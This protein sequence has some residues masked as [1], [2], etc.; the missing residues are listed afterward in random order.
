MTAIDVVLERYREADS[1]ARL[2][3]SLGHRDLRTLFEWIEEEERAATVTEVRALP[4]GGTA[5]A[6]LRSLLRWLP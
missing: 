5:V 2:D 6:P 3:M 1:Q 4:A